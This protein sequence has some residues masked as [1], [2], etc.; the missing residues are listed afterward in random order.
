MKV[1]SDVLSRDD[2]SLRTT[3]FKAPF[4][5]CHMR[6]T[7]NTLDMPLPLALAQCVCE[8]TFIN[9]FFISFKH[10][11][12]WMKQEIVENKHNDQILENFKITFKSPFSL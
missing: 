2:I 5:L 1:K 11:K 6:G 8:N 4:P 7:S 9:S 3:L 12:T 10:P